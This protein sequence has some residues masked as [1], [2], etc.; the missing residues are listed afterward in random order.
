MPKHVI[1]KSGTQ[2]EMLQL[3]AS[4]AACPGALHFSTDTNEVW[5]GASNGSLIGPFLTQ[6]AAL[7][8]YGAFP[9]DDAAA[10][11]GVPISGLYTL[12]NQND[13]D[14]PQGSLRIRVE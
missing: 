8:V 11:A 4:L 5:I 6:L 3:G 9:G 10:G 7:Q 1:Q 13:Y 12:T 14:L 2:A